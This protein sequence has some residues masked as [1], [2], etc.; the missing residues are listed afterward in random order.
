MEPLGCKGQYS[1]AAEGYR[2]PLLPLLQRSLLGLPLDTVSTFLTVLPCRLFNRRAGSWA[3][4]SSM[5]KCLL[6]ATAQSRCNLLPAPTSHGYVSY[7]LTHLPVE[8]LN[9]CSFSL[10]G[11]TKVR[12]GSVSSLDGNIKYQTSRS[13]RYSRNTKRRQGKNWK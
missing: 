11:D 12:A 3:S 2:H 8:Q 13:T 5:A 4:M 1:R 9:N 6:A 10:T 7:M